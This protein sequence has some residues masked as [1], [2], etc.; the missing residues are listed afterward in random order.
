MAVVIDDP[1]IVKDIVTLIQKVNQDYKNIYDSNGEYIWYEGTVMSSSKKQFPQ[2]VTSE[3]NYTNPHIKK[4][5]PD[6]F[7]E[8]TF[9]IQAQ[10]F[11]QFHKDHNTTLLKLTID[12]DNCFILEASRK[13]EEHIIDELRFPFNPAVIDTINDFTEKAEELMGDE[14]ASFEFDDEIINKILDYNNDPFNFILDFDTNEISMFKYESDIESENYLNLINNKKFISGIKNGS[15]VAT[16]GL[17][18]INEFNGNENLFFVTLTF[19]HKV[20][21]TEQIFVI[22][23]F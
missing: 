2:Y 1:K 9:T 7:S 10:E 12:D 15:V 8:N 18:S 13:K 11:F 3:V 14:I 23:D 22:T 17:I 19:N 6:F 5:I 20:F 21:K 16:E 4:G